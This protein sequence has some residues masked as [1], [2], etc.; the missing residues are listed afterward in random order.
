MPTIPRTMRI[1]PV[2]K[3]SV[4]TLRGAMFEVYPHPWA[5]NRRHTTAHKNCGRTIGP[6]VGPRVENEHLF[7]YTPPLRQ[8]RLP[9]KVEPSRRKGMDFSTVEQFVMHLLDI[10]IY[11]A[12]PPCAPTS[13]TPLGPV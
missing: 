5:H 1:I 10:A 8:D 9:F 4:C 6:K 12:I 2:I 11:V 13:N 3:P 7:A